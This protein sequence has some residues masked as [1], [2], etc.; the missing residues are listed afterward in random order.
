MYAKEYLYFTQNTSNTAFISI[1]GPAG[2]IID[3]KV[4]DSWPQIVSFKADRFWS[5]VPIKT[6]Q[7]ISTT[8]AFSAGSIST[9]G[10]ISLGSVTLSGSSSSLAV[11]GGDVTT[12]GSLKAS[13]GYAVGNTQAGMKII[14]GVINSN[15]TKKSGVGFT[16]KRQSG[17]ATG[18]YH[19]TFDSGFTEAPAVVATN[20]EADPDNNKRTTLA[21]LNFHSKESVII[22]WYNTDDGR[23]LNDVKFSFIAIGK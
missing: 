8:G 1:D 13:N 16:V 22:S 12:S 6:N 15:A 20:I 10:S 3:Q 2:L 7:I 21:S 18:R 11:S 19:I 9:T 17:Q 4:N 23:T 5:Y 14:S